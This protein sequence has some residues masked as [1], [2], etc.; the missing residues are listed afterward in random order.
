[1]TRLRLRV[2]S[3]LLEAQREA[4]ILTTFNEADMQEVIA[5]RRQYKQRFTEKHGAN[6]GF[7]SF[8]V[9]AA[10]QALQRYPAVNA[11]I[12]GEEIVY[13]HYH[14]IGVAVGT[15]RG[16]MVPVL[17]DATTLSFAQIES[18]I[19]DIAE[20]ARSGKI[21]PDELMGGTFSISNGGIYGSMLSTP[22]LNPPQ[23]A[24]LG[25]HRIIPR[26]VVR[27]EQIVIRPMMYLALSYDHRLIDGEQ[28]VR[29][30]VHIKDSL[31]EPARLLLDL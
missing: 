18:R 21:A 2:A 23:T 28:A 11:F 5:L 17:R 20:R 1:M 15:E 30:L 24:I 13:N 31:E 12:E 7:M 16:L 4:A 27:E 25:M 29:F 9:R 22:I 26:P 6:L 19:A 14:D 10:V 8:F 3:R